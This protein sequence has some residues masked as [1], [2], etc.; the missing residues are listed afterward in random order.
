MP[1]KSPGGRRVD[2]EPLRQA[3][4]NVGWT[5]RRG[6]GNPGRVYVAERAGTRCCSRCMR[7]PPSPTNVQEAA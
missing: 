3:A 5:F 7:P 1:D 2:L 4:M 6:Y